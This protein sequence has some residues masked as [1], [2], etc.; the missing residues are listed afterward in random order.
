VGSYHV[1]HDVTLSLPTV[2][3]REGALRVLDPVLSRE[4]Q[5]ALQR[6]AEALRSAR[7]DSAEARSAP[8]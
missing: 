2:V 6:S 7:V 4:E 1:E 8:A 5:E 3:G